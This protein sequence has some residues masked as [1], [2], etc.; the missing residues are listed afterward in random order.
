MTGINPSQRIVRARRGRA[1]LRNEYGVFLLA[2]TLA[3]LSGSGCSFMFVKS[4]ATTPRQA[5]P[6]DCTPSYAAPVVD[7]VLVGTV[8]LGVAWGAA[9]GGPALRGPYDFAHLAPNIALWT[10][11]AA[12][13]VSAVYGYIKVGDCRSVRARPS[14][15][16]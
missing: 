13:A 5:Q 10:G 16:P 15:S 8:G 2:V 9:Q 14:S 3:V 11:V 7:T 6:P 4:P 1:S 12:V